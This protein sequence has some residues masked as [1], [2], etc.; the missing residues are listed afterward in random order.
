M[1]EENNEEVR[2][3]EAEIERL[4]AEVAALQRQQQDNHQ[5][6]TFPFRGQMQDAM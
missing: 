2:M 4:H 5:G 3:L 6:I 1:S